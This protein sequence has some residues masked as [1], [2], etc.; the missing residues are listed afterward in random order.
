MVLAGVGAAFVAT[1]VGSLA[2]AVSS[3]PSAGPQRSSLADRVNAACGRFEVVD[4]TTGGEFDR[5][6]PGTVQVTCSRGDGS[7]FVVAVER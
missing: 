7:L 6:A 5:L 2:L 1:A 4:W 3:S